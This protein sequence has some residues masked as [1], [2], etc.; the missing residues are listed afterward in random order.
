MRNSHDGS[1]DDTVKALVHP[2][3]HYPDI[4]ERYLMGKNPPFFMGRKVCP[5][6]RGVGIIREEETGKFESHHCM[7]CDGS[8]IIDETEKSEE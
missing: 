5:H 6:C 1:T 2:T 4:S 3:L 7:Q 8:G